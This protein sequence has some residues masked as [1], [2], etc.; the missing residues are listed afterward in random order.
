MPYWVN[1]A[2][3]IQLCLP[4]HADFLP[5]K[6]SYPRYRVL[7]D[8]KRRREINVYFTSIR[9]NELPSIWTLLVSRGLS[10][11]RMRLFFTAQ[12]LG[13]RV[14]A[15]P[16]RRHSSL[17]PQSTGTCYSLR[18][19][20]HQKKRAPSQHAANNRTTG[21][22]SSPRSWLSP[23]KRRFVYLPCTTAASTT[24]YAEMHIQ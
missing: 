9:A 23:S 16:R 6:Y 20:L 14:I 10:P 8:G 12:K 2:D 4:Q 24:Y 17:L 19:P 3:W 13:R 18:V 22:C 21:G 5:S 11:R 7:R 1:N 15:P